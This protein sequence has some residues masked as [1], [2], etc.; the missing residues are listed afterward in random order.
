MDQ[1]GCFGQSGTSV[2]AKMAE[3]SSTMICRA[4]ACRDAFHTPTLGIDVGT[5][6]VWHRHGRQEIRDR[7][8]LVGDIAVGASGDIGGGL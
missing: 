1:A 4:A 5:D 6:A 7:R 8:D 3:A 2:E